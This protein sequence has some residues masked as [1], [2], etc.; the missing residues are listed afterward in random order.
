MAGPTAFSWVAVY[1]AAFSWVAV[2][3]AAFNWVA[4]KE[5]SAL[6]PAKSLTTAGVALRLW[7]DHGLLSDMLSK[8]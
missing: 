1:P 7:N 5:L 2:Y 4:V 6:S 8:G 3:P